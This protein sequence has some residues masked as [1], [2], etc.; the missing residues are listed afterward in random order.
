MTD[1]R[2][3]DL[4][5]RDARPVSETRA[6]DNQTI[7]GIAISRAEPSRLRSAPDMKDK[8]GR[9]GGIEVMEELRDIVN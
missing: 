4:P 5:R 9:I 1:F 3:P 2:G 6:I 8:I 7:E